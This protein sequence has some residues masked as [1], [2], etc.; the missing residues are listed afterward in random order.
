HRLSHPYLEFMYLNNAYHFYSPEPGAATHFWMRVYYDTGT[1]NEFGAPKLEG[2]WVK[3]PDLDEQGQ[4]GSA[5]GL[6][7]YRSLSLTEN[8]VNADPSPLLYTIDKDGQIQPGELLKNRLINSMNG[9]HWRKAT[10]GVEPPEPVL[11]VPL[12]PNVAPEAQ[13]Q[14]PTYLSMR[15]MQS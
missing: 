1:K 9:G 4:R 7:Y 15:L 8:I 12:V 5:V 6:E 14:R 2:I 13:Y 11:E 10:V 3:I